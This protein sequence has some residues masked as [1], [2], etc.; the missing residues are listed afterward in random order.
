MTEERRLLV[1]CNAAYGYACEGFKTGYVGLNFAEKS[2][3]RQ[4]DG[5][6]GLRYAD[7]VEKLSVVAECLY[8]KKH[9]ARGV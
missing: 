5:K 4:T 2:T 6:H 3:R 1:A 9:G 8:V 7:E